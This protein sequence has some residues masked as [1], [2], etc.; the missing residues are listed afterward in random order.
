MSR[1]CSTCD[2][3]CSTKRS[4]PAHPGIPIAE[5]YF[6]RGNTRHATSAGDE[7]STEL[8]IADQNTAIRRARAE[9][10]PGLCAAATA[11][12][13]KALVQS[14]TRDGA[15]RSDRLAEAE[16]AIADALELPLDLIDRATVHQARA[17]VVRLR[18]PAESVSAFEA[19]FALL[20]PD[21]PFW[22]EIA[23]EIV[24]TL[25]RVDR[26]EEAVQRGTEYLNQVRGDGK[27]S[28]LGM[29][30]LALGE[31]LLASKRWDDARR[32]L[33]EG[34]QLVRGRAPVNEALARLHLARLGLATG[35]SGLSEEHLRFLQ[36]H[37]EELDP[38]TRR[39]LDLMDATAVAARGDRD[40]HRAALARTLSTVKG[41]RMRVGLRLEIAQLDLAAGRPVDDV[42]GLVLRGLETE[43]E[44]PHDAVLTDLLCNHCGSLA[45]STREKALHW[46][47]ERR[48]S[49]WARLQHQT[50]RT[51]E[52]RSTLRAALAG[53]LDNHER[54]VQ[55]FH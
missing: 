34:L 35:D 19:A 13:A 2:C 31:A 40:G 26:V 15:S 47:R 54:L 23:A 28:E 8:V 6:H 12:W 20:L 4:R 33:E 39:D 51:E 50:G 42:D 32:R 27:G 9:G 14:A 21:D 46:A 44:R 36:D 37:R 16:A 29:L 38:L 17:H 11:A 3:A 25:L 55:R 45:R 53:D 22:A 18:S 7:R 30:H 52:A 5:L 1:S 41:E 10:N 48:P 43:L 24:A 49:I